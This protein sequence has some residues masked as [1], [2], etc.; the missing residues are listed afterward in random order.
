MRLPSF[1]LLCVLGALFL[2]AP[3]VS[4]PAHGETLRL[5]SQVCY[6]NAA[7]GI[8]VDAA[9]VSRLAFRC[10]A[11]PSGY[12]DRWVWLKLRDARAVEAMPQQWQLVT[13]QVQFD[14]MAMLVVFKDGGVQR[15]V[16]A[17]GAIGGHAAMG[18]MLRF[19]VD[20][21]GR[22]I[23]ELYV[24]F[25]R[26]DDLSFLRKLSAQSPASA[27]RLDGRWRLLIGAFA[28]VLLCAFAYNLVIHAGQRLAFQRWYLLWS[29]MTLGYGLSWSNAIAQV[30][31]GFAG[32]V[33]VRADYAFLAGMFAACILFFVS[34]IENGVLPPW[35]IRCGR[36]LACV[37]LLLG[38]GAWSGWIASPLI[39]DR[40][41]NI[42][43]AMATLCAGTGVVL[44]IKRQSRVVWF[45]VVGWTPVLAVYLLRLARNLGLLEQNDI[46]DMATFATLAFESLVLSMA[47]AD[48]FRLLRNERDAARQARSV[49]EIESETLRKAA[50]TDFLTGL[51]NRAAFQARLRIMCEAPGQQFILLL[52]D[53]DHLKDINDRL[54]HDGG[55]MLLENVG[56]GLAQAGGTLAHASRIGGDEFAILLSGGEAEQRRVRD[57]LAALQDRTLTHAGRSWALS[58]SIGCARFPQDADTADALFKNADLALYQAKQQGRHQ[59][60]DYDAS[61]RARLDR[62]QA[63]SED[64]HQGLVRGEFSF[65]FQP[66][67]DLHSRAAV[68][69]E[70][71]L[72]WQHPVHGLMTPAIFGEMLGDR[73]IG[74]MVQQH[75]LETGLEALHRHPEM[76]PS[77]SMNFTAAQLDGPPAAA[78]LLARLDD[79]GIAP[80]RLCI[81]VTEDVVLNR[82]INETARVLGLLHDAGVR[83][84]LDDFGTGYASLIHLKQLPFDILK[85]DRSFTLGLFEDD[86]QSEE[87]IRAIIGLG[88]GLRKQVVAEGIETERQCERL[89]E[90]G[91]AFGQGYLFARPA[92]IRLLAQP[93]VPPVAA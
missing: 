34:V 53:V 24:G 40:S 77:L 70:A 51:G 79:H 90:M 33:A 27:T 48:R 19:T 12:H 66:I 55:D 62:R 10:H 15:E 88:Q 20:R 82:T 3:L 72:R 44:A 54:G 43:W 89:L 25:L 73:K 5:R 60:R 39:L 84:A 50:R 23:R 17:P 28:G 21:P 42:V 36:A 2:S 75:V 41:L 46:V 92:P 61:L 9:S 69:S 68:S 64:A 93:Y 8:S 59:L 29:A 47:I 1:L 13:D 6:A 58:L 37:N 74:L 87:I 76:L 26:M 71:L 56:L 11:R 49:I 65:H 18:G 32:P 38:F 45:Y 63:F 52:I 78:R 83:I 16:V 31:P 85:I 14:R 57:A 91:C 4:A 22:E 80:E 67:V 86:G 30:I 81:E 35:L 7:A